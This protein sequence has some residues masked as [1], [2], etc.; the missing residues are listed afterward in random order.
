MAAEECDL[1]IIVNAQK[2]TRR[3]RVIEY[4]E[5][6]ELAFPSPHGPDEMFTVT[7]S[8]GPEGCREGILVEDQNVTCGNGMVFDVTRTDKS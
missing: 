2:K 6:V 5:V 4:A 7:Y 8:C 1:E 3:T